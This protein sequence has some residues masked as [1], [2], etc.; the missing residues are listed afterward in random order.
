MAAFVS[1]LWSQNCGKITL[2]QRYIFFSFNNK[3]YLLKLHDND[4]PYKV[5]YAQPEWLV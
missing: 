2:Q 5:F 3:G 1:N 4:F